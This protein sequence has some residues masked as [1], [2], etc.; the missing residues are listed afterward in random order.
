MVFVA[1]GR[2]QEM[3]NSFRK[4]VETRYRVRVYACRVTA[5]EYLH[6]LWQQ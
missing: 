5:D 4:D 2:S 3:I 1:V 6:V